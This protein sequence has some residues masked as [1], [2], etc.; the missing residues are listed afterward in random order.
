MEDSVA[1]GDGGPILKNGIVGLFLLLN[2]VAV[3]SVV[4]PWVS[5]WRAHGI[6][7]LLVEAAF[8]LLIGL[9]RVAYQVF[10][11]KKTF[12]R[13]LSDSVEAVMGWLSYF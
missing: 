8:L 3:F 9:P 12:R 5:D 1:K 13:S 7:V 11:K 6:T 2:A 10:W 4:N